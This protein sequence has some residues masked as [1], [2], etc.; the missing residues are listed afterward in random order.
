MTK[1]TAL[2]ALA[3]LGFTSSAGA[4]EAFDMNPPNICEIVA[5]LAYDEAVAAGN[6]LPDGAYESAM[7]VCEDSQ[8]ADD[9]DTTFDARTVA[10]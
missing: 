3:I 9:I 5:E 6:G 2:I 7:A 8:L 10:P 1:L 4:S